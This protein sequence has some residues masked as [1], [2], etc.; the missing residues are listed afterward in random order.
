MSAIRFFTDEDVY[1][2]LA[3]QLRR[4][5]FDA[6]STPE[7]Q[8][9]GTSDEAQLDWAATNGYVIV[10]FNTADFVQLLAGWLQTRRRHLG[11]VA[12]TQRP[13]GE[14]IRRLVNLGNALTAEDMFDRFEFLGD[15]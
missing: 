11:I 9:R 8:R 15:W 4:L 2:Q 7:A 10:T 14:L 12:S 13:V 5:G 6:I 1:A 3:I